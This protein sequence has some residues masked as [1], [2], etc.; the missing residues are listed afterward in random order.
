MVKL[1][2]GLGPNL[3]LLWVAGVLRSHHPLIILPSRVPLTCWSLV[4]SPSASSRQKTQL[5][6]RACRSVFGFSQNPCESLEPLG[7]MAPWLFNI[8]QCF[9][10]KRTKTWFWRLTLL[11]VAQSTNVK[12]L[13]NKRKGH[14]R[15]RYYSI[16][17]CFLK[18]M[19]RM[20][21]SNKIT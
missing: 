6:T 11:K 2:T 9:W 20:G 21:M 8:V 14:I 10:S 1:P 7:P 16:F 15:T 3:L 5:L 17:P 18:Q 19:C 13:Q 12:W 4:H